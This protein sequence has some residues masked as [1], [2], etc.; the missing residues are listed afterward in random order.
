MTLLMLLRMVQ[1]AFLIPYMMPQETPEKPLKTRL[2]RHWDETEGRPE[3][4]VRVLNQPSDPKKKRLLDKDLLDKDLL[5][6]DLLD[7]DLL[8]KDLL[9]KDLLDKDLLD[10]DLMDKD[11][12]DKDLLDKDLLDKDL[13]DKDL[14]DKD[15][16]DKD[17]LISHP[18]RLSFLT[19]RSKFS[20]ASL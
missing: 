20:Q 16:L 17:F 10:K 8:D 4:A 2:M 19:L 12:L 11:L 15:L 9:D 13:L 1:T 3:Q 6:K 7:K 14:L 5:D 18:L